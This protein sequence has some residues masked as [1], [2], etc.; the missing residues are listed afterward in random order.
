[1]WL[2]WKVNTVE[3]KNKDG[4][5]SLLIPFMTFLNSRYFNNYNSPVRNFPPKLEELTPSPFQ[6]NFYFRALTTCE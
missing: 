1:M 5:H 6:V 3:D 4:F 2:L